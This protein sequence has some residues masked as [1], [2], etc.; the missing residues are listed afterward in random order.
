R[1]PQPHQIQTDLTMDR[2]HRIVLPL[3]GLGPDAL[4]ITH[5]PLVQ[6]ALGIRGVDSK[7]ICQ[8]HSTTDPFF[9]DPSFHVN[10]GCLTS[11]LHETSNRMALI[12]S[13]VAA[14]YLG[15]PLRIGPDLYQYLILRSHGPS[16]ALVPHLEEFYHQ[17]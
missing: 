4:N 15:H 7:S 1:L 3:R 13:R 12:H 2:S 14:R 17:T 6:N 9:L 5:L 8:H 11:Y 10:Q 16:L